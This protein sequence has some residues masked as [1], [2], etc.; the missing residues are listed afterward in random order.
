[1]TPELLTANPP[2]LAIVSWYCAV[3]LALGQTTVSDVSQI[4]LDA[5]KLI[6]TGVGPVGVDAPE[7]LAAG[8]P[9]PPPPHALNSKVADASTVIAMR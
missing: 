4:A 9:P 8:A 6:A 7:P 5:L 3:V 2:A 1:M